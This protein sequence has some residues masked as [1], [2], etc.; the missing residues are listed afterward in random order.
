V[1]L[2]K[3]YDDVSDS[4]LSLDGRIDADDILVL[5][6]IANGGQHVTFDRD[7]AVNERDGERTAQSNHVSLDK[8]ADKVIDE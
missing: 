5:F 2:G 8:I 4:H 7:T 3:R 1:D 6:L